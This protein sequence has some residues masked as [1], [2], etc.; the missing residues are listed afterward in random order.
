M[1]N[2]CAAVACRSGYLSN[3]ADGKVHSFPFPLKKPELVVHWEKFV[4][5]RDWKPSQNSVLCEKHFD[6]K[7][8]ERFTKKCHLK[9]KMNPVPTIHD[10][11]L[12]QRSSSLPTPIH[13]IKYQIYQIY[14]LAKKL[15]L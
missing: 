9:W 3:S 2:T 7:Y 13:I 11:E 1:V 14:I 4:N 12:L 8:I 10:K 5:R 15:T 6:E